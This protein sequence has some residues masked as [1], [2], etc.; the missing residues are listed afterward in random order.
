MKRFDF[1]MLFL[2]SMFGAGYAQVETNYYQEG[3][4]SHNP[5]QSE[6]REMNIRRMPSFDLAQLQKE[7]ADNDETRGL[8]RFGKGFDVSYSLADGQW[9]DVDG[10]RL[11][12]TGDKVF[13]TKV[14]DSSYTID[15][16]GWKPG[17]YVVRGIVG[18]K[19]F[20]EKVV[21]K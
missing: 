11:W 9:E 7:D 3:E 21:V 4:T 13:Q 2:L 8:F 18:G 20:S 19:V 6:R 10:G 1:V 17:V 14:E 12:T 16:T 5:W 15:T